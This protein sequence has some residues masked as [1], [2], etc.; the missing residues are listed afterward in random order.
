[1]GFYSCA[2]ST[3][4]NYAPFETTSDG[5]TDSRKWMPIYST[6]SSNPSSH[7]VLPSQSLHTNQAM[8]SFL[9]RTVTLGITEP[10]AGAN[11]SSVSAGSAN[12]A[13]QASTSKGSSIG[14]IAGGVGGGVAAVAILAVVGFLLCSRRRQRPSEPRGGGALP[15]TEQMAAV[16]AEKTR[17]S[18]YPDSFTDEFPLPSRDGKHSSSAETHSIAGSD[19]LLPPSASVASLSPRT[20][21]A[22]LCNDSVSSMHSARSTRPSSQHRTKHQPSS[23]IIPVGISELPARTS[24]DVSAVLNLQPPPQFARPRSDLLELS[25]MALKTPTVEMAVPLVLATATPVELD[26]T[27]VVRPDRSRDGSRQT[28]RQPSRQASRQASRQT[29][30]DRKSVGE[31]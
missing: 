10:S 5:E 8:I 12:S 28:S 26:G 4:D 16:A 25:S 3:S 20:H 14:A 21:V 29:S 9:V 23:G 2:A 6:A 18:R 30:R 24:R 27:S 19:M 1:M 7:I 17:Q 13:A 31:S 15:T 11:S 22:D